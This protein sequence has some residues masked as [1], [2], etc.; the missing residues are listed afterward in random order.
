MI[1]SPQKIIHS[2][3]LPNLQTCTRQDL[4]E[5]FDN[6]WNLTEV[7][8][9]GLKKKEAFYLAPYHQLRHPLIFYYCHPVVLYVNKLRIA[10]LINEA[11]NPYF[12]RLF[13]TG[14]DEMSW[15][16]LSKNQMHWPELEE[17]TAY[18]AEVYQLIKH[19]I[20]THPDLD[21]RPITM[22]SP[23][24]ALMMGMEHERIHF[25]TSSVLIRE[26][27]I[28]LVC[29]PLQWPNYF[30]LQSQTMTHPIS[31]V[32]YPT[33]PLL[34]VAE[35]QVNIG[36]P[37]EWPSYGWDNEYGSWEA[38]IKSFRANKFLISNGEFYEFVI[39]GG[40][41]QPHY[42]SEDGWKW[43]T[44][45]NAKWPSFW[46]QHGPAG[47]HEY[48]LRL[49]FEIVA[50]QWSWPAE[51]NFHEAK[52]FAAWKSEQNHSDIPY[53][54][55]TEAEHH[56]I[57]D[58]NTSHTA[59]INFVYGAE[60]PVDAMPATPSGF[61]DVV[62]NSWQWCEDHFA[63]LPGFEVH[64]LYDDFS[65]P[66]FDGKHHIIMGGSFISTGDEAS[67]FARF[68]FR[69]HFYQ[70]AGCRLVQPT[71][72]SKPL[73]TT[74]LDAPP[75]HVGTQACCSK[76]TT[77]QQNGYESQQLLNQYLLLHYGNVEDTITHLHAPENSMAFPKRC[78]ELLC[79]F[80]NNPE[81]V[82]DLGC[83]VGGTAFELAR[84]V[85]EVIGIDLSESFIKTAN[86]MKTMGKIDYLRKEEGEIYSSLVAE[87]D[88][89]IDRTRISFQVG[90]ACALPADFKP[91]DA[92]LLANLLC[93]LPSPKS[94]LQR[95]GGAMGIIKIGG[96][97]MITS[98]Y[99]WLAA[100]T[101]KAAWLG[102]NNDIMSIHG[103]HTI[104]DEHFEL[105]HESNMPLVIREHARK[106]EYIIAHATVWKRIK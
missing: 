89:A 101:P 73:L 61:H 67:Q 36:K 82:L 98:P 19:L 102:G 53:R 15:D 60:T 79:N 77:T 46:V 39:A 85:P 56:R 25:E 65:S 30:S 32:D 69:P 42:W 2:L 96:I 74:C 28:H 22:Q 70:H 105:I 97:L 31:G 43:R 14:V 76:Q 84:V 29:K 72:L 58:L 49:C 8:F 21:K 57:R 47:S 1:I 7:L 23:F 11:I 51:I 41:Q 48:Q 106:F 104:L 87:I 88:P 78:A 63:A 54:L 103:L 90:D 55:I 24:W 13:E 64:S 86:L 37:S 71:E 12:E 40:Y 38:T 35:G 75:P 80:T 45:R 18:R 10:G 50:M 62:G 26:L 52:A 94:C 68:H 91:C 100:H 81:R 17:I 6:T 16:D 4:L 20:E 27:P 66:C 93:R 99:S 95:M 5:Y 44:F 34:D 33:N 92:V 59:N 9:S 3:P 83:A